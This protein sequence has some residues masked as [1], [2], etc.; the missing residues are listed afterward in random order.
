M[1]ETISNTQGFEDKLRFRAYYLSFFIS[2]ILLVAKYIAYQI[3]GSKAIMSD[4]L[5]SI[6]NVV[7]PFL[8]I[9]ILRNSIKPADRE[10]PY[11]HG[12]LEYF[13]SAIEGGLIFFAALTIIFE[14][15]KALIRGVEVKEIDTGLYITVGAA[16][17]NLALG[18]FVLK[19]GKKYQSVALK[20][21]GKHILSD[22]W[23]TAGVTLGLIIVKF[24]GLTFFDPLVAAFVGLSLGWEGFKIVRESAGGLLDEEDT[25]LLKEI[26]EIFTRQRTPGV[27]HIH[28]TRVIRSGRY[29]HIDAHVV[30]PEFWSIDEAHE[31]VFKFERAVI[32]D[33]S[34][35]GEIHFHLDPCRRAY[36]HAC[37]LSDCSIR[38]SKFE[39]H[40]PF[41][42]DDLVNPNEPL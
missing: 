12:K 38:K 22:V 32:K 19:T 1:G 18:Y 20:A 28:H 16:I 29:H 30:V 27:I 10:H 13:S 41:T 26:S 8:G 9:I 21:N 33:Y 40:L 6:I 36:C 5:E 7:M 11:G 24:T 31:R 2:I 3:T 34:V 37:D 15:V 39:K 35:D 42:I 14:A 17:V 4:A 23:T 25:G